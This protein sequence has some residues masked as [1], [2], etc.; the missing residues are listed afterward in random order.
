MAG[1]VEQ[2]GTLAQV[3]GSR[4]QDGAEKMCWLWNPSI[5]VVK[6]NPLQAVVW[7]LLFKSTYPD[8]AG[9]HITAGARITNKHG[10]SGEKQCSGES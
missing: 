10:G 5:V 8:Q 7:L 9:P 1:Q 4:W 6:A 3:E 2:V